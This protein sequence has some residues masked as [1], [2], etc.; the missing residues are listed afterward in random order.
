MDR[1]RLVAA[2]LVKSKTIAILQ[3]GNVVDLDMVKGPIRLKLRSVLPSTD[4]AATDFRKHPELYTIGRGEF[5]VL[6]VEP[7]KSEILPFW[8]FK[9][10]DLAAL[11]AKKILALFRR[12]RKEKDFVGMDMARK[13]LQMGY[14][15]SRRYAN[16]RS[17]KKYVGSVPN[18]LQGLSGSHG[19]KI[20][21]N[22][23]DAEKA[24]SASI[25]KEAWETV[26]ADTSYQRAKKLRKLNAKMP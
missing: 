15:R 10:P 21:P 23:P 1:V 9:T 2:E 13:F 20:A 4:Y 19:R 25:F 5:G 3:K 26:E 6:T 18:A 7:Y 24:K 8:K 16:H 12:Y 17:G 11:S 22:E 14:T